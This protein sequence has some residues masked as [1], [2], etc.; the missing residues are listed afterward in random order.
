MCQIEPV[1]ATKFAQLIK[2]SNTICIF[3]SQSIIEV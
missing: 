2:S 3:V 1:K